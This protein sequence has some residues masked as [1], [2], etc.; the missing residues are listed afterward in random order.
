MNVAWIIDIRDGTPQNFVFPAVIH[1]P[2]QEKKSQIHII[3]RV[4]KEQ[5]IYG[6]ADRKRCPPPPYG[7]LCVISV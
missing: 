1:R 4:V 2:N 6:Q 7:Q 3:R 5:V